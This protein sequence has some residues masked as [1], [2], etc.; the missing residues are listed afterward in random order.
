MLPPM[1]EGAD[2][3]PDYG[4]LRLW[5]ALH[6]ATRGVGQQDSESGRREPDQ[7]L[8]WLGNSAYRG[9]HVA[10]IAI[11]ERPP[12]RRRH[13]RDPVAPHDLG[14]G[15]GAKG[16]RQG[17]WPL[18]LDVHRI[19]SMPL[20]LMTWSSASAGPEARFAPRSSCDR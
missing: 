11:P 12:L 9:A 18:R 7:A 1:E 3:R 13:A 17:G 6:R 14:G 2:N 8:T 5:V 10:N 20:R 16:L 19:A 15:R 4:L